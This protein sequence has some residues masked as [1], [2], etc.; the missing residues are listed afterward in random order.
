MSILGEPSVPVRL[1]KSAE[2]T[3]G[4]LEH[5]A[6]P[7]R[8]ALAPAA[9]VPRGDGR[10]EG[11]GLRA[12]KPGSRVEAQE[13]SGRFRFHAVKEWRETMLCSSAA[14]LLTVAWS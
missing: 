1:E 11:E 5:R 8:R 4:R 7:G 14:R 12:A 2:E 3:P 9:L 6:W 10:G 13:N